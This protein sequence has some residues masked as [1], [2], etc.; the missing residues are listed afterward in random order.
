LF[1]SINE[2]L[3]KLRVLVVSYPPHTS[4]IFQVLDRLLFGRLK[5]AKKHLVGD[6][7]EFAEL[8]HVVR[9][10]KAYELETTSTTIRASFQQTALDYEQRDGI[11][12]LIVNDQ[13]LW[14]YT[15]FQ[16]V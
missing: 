12:Y 10:F 13:R 8:D 15:E 7:E 9:I 4:Q 14:R 5:A 3:A 11:W 1:R 6:L 16:E 2:E